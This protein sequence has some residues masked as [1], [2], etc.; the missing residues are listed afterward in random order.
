MPACN[1][2]NA[3]NRA[4]ALH[5]IQVLCPMIAVYAINT[6]REPARLFITTGK[7]ILSVEGTMQGDLLSMTIYICM[8]VHMHYLRS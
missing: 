5:N 2:F 7:E 1:A 8:Y 3:L 6:Y 4:A